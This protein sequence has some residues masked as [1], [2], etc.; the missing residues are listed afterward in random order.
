MSK[1]IIR[2]QLEPAIND[3]YISKKKAI[4]WLPFQGLGPRKKDKYGF[5]GVIMDWKMF[6]EFFSYKGVFGYAKDVIC[7]P[8]HKV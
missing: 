5:M 3:Y 6:L 4:M 1:P 2:F 7:F 8:A